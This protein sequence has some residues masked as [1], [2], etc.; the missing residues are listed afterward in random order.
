HRDRG[1][2]KPGVAARS[3]DVRHRDRGVKPGVAA[4]SVKA[5]TGGRGV[6]PRIDIGAKAAFEVIEDAG[7]KAAITAAGLREL[8]PRLCEVLPCLAGLLPRLAEVLPR[9]IKFRRGSVI[10]NSTHGDVRSFGPRPMHR[11]LSKTLPAGSTR[12]C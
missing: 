9:L 6:K 8:F 3:A 10:A 7:V 12:T 1:E 5:A 4:R 11:S 2:I